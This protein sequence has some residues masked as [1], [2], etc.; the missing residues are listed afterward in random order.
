M[1]TLLEKLGTLFMLTI[2]VLA[3]G[4][5]SSKKS[6]E[7][8]EDVAAAQEEVVETTEVAEEAAEEVA[9]AAAEN[10]VASS[11]TCTSGEDTRV[12]ESVSTGETSCDVNYSK[13]GSTEKVAWAENDSSWCSKIQENIQGNLSTAGFSCQ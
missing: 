1:K 8:K 10:T 3:V 9:E 5:C 11:V 4:A 7:V 12:I 13:F 2:L 6:E